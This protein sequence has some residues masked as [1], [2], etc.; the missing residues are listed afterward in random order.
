MTKNGLSLGKKAQAPSET[1]ASSL[2][3]STWKYRHCRSEDSM[4]QSQSDRCCETPVSCM[5]CNHIWMP[6]SI[7]NTSFLY[8]SAGL[9]NFHFFHRR[10]SSNK[11]ASP[12]SSRLPCSP[13]C[14]KCSSMLKYRWGGSGRIFFVSLILIYKY[15]HLNIH[16]WHSNTWQ[17]CSEKD[18]NGM[19]L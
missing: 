1:Q 9:S 6:A 12:S 18:S 16:T 19:C 3:S 13:T 17:L 5:F 4:A 8:T 11:K 10:R 2:S 7:S 15:Y 14:E